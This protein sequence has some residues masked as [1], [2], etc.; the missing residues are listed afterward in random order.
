[1]TARHNQGNTRF[2][3]HLRKRDTPDSG[4]MAIDAATRESLELVRTMTGTRDGSLLVLSK[5]DQP[6]R[7]F[8]QAGAAGHGL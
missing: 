1:M 3:N 7:L 8:A 2:P 4:R 5:R 6:A